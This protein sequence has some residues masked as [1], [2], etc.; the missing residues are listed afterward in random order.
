[1]QKGSAS[2][3][4]LPSD[5]QLAR[6]A[7]M[8]QEYHDGRDPRLRQALV[9]HYLDVAHRAAASLFLRRV[10]NAVGFEDYLQ[11]ARVGLLE[12]ID[13]YDPAREASFAT[14]AGYRVRGAILNGLE[15]T[16]E[17]AAQAAQRRHARLRERTQSLENPDAQSRS[18]GSGRPDSSPLGQFAGMV[19]VAIML[20]M[21]YVME[22]NGEWNPAGADVAS[23]PYRSVELDR[24]RSRLR[25][26]VGALPERERVIVSYHYFEHMEFQMIAEVLDVS[27]GRVAQLHARALRLIREGYDALEE[28][29]LEL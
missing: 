25:L 13:R 11:Y 6:E 22:D 16:T 24:A 8:W 18:A 14:F 7:L 27:K 17:L 4:D 1:M 15:Q 2:G 28:F 12:A 3:V 9:Q 21:G 26:L 29:D 19:D 5:A 10:N 23:D 20:A